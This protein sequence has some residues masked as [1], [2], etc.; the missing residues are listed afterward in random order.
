[1]LLDGLRILLSKILLEVISMTQTMFYEFESNELEELVDKHIR[2]KDYE[3]DLWQE[4][5][6]GCAYT[7]S[8]SGRLDKCDKRDLIEWVKTGNGI[9][10]SNHMILDAL[11]K[12]RI[13]PAGNYLIRS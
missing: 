12:M 6:S 5:Q 1:M 13:I 7:F 11:C 9:Y 8:V 3:F 10:R 2:I 4:S